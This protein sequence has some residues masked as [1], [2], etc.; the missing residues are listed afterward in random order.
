M[1]F[2][3]RSLIP[4]SGSDVQNKE[5]TMRILA[6]TLIALLAVFPVTKAQETDVLK[7]GSF[8]ISSLNTAFA[9]QGDF[10]GEYRIHP[11]QIELKVTKADIRISEHCP[12]KGHRL[13]SA[14]KFILVTKTEEGRRKI[15]STG[16]EFSLAQVMGP[17]DSYSLGEMYFKIPIQASIDLSQHWLLVQIDETTLDDPEEGPTKGFAYAQSCKDIFSRP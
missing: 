16:Q 13:L 10:E 9:T 3:R 4:A 2:V 1:P 6:S 12:Y 8:Q 15:V 11:D 14:V 7:A 17:G 5:L